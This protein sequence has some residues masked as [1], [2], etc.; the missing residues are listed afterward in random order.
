MQPIYLRK[1][2]TTCSLTLAQPA[3]LSAE[4]RDVVAY[5]APGGAPVARWPWHHAKPTRRNK[6]VTLNCVTRSVIWL[7]D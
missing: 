3:S 5:D 7:D 2:K 1:E 6:R 4:Q